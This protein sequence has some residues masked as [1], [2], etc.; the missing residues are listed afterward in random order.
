[1]TGL[2][3]KL[4]IGR[5]SPASNPGCD[6]TLCGLSPPPSFP[7]PTGSGPCLGA[8]TTGNFYVSSLMTLLNVVGCDISSQALSP[9]SLAHRD[10]MA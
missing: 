8:L 2:L 6:A 4:H 10:F 3:N 9:N 7:H 1:M 5:Y